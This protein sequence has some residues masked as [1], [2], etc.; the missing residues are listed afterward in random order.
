MRRFVRRAGH[1][2][3]EHPFEP[4]ETMAERHVGAAGML[5]ELPCLQ[6]ERERRTAQAVGCLSECSEPPPDI[7]TSRCRTK[8][9]LFD[10]LEDSDHIKFGC[11]TVEKKVCCCLLFAVCCWGFARR[12][13]V[14]VE[15]SMTTIS[16][17]YT[18]LSPAPFH[19][20]T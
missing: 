18:Y 6:R 19:C 15:Q 1:A 2:A 9:Q 11:S 16:N 5:Q 17:T 14:H 12:G 8:L 4:V 20:Y 13:S 10:F 3:S 7:I